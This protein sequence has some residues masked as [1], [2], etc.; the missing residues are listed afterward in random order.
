MKITKAIR[1]KDSRVIKGTD[2]LQTKIITVEFW[3]HK[4]SISVN[5]N[6]GYFDF[7]D[8]DNEYEEISIE[9]FHRAFN[10]VKNRINDI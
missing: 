5:N 4:Q 3:P 2:E 7:I 10:I 9:S 1:Q 6:P 8:G